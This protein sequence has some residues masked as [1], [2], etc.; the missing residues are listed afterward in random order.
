MLPTPNPYL[1]VTPWPVFLPDRADPLGTHFPGHA[2][3]PAVPGCIFFCW[4]PRCLYES[5]CFVIRHDFLSYVDPM[6]LFIP[7]NATSSTMLSLT[8]LLPAPALFAQASLE[9]HGT[10]FLFSAPSGLLTPSFLD[11]LLDGMLFITCVTCTLPGLAHGLAFT[12]SCIDL[13]SAAKFCFLLLKL[14]LII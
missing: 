10:W 5:A 4:H 14:F 8:S 9:L 2:H 11:L 7:S 3:V 13:V 12:T 6:V 1:F